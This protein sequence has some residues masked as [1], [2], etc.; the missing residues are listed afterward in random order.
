MCSQILFCT[1]RKNLL[2]KMCSLILTYTIDHRI[3][4]YEQNIILN[5]LL[6]QQKKINLFNWRRKK[7]RISILLKY[8]IVFNV[9]SIFYLTHYH[10]MPHFDALKIYSCGKL[11]KKRRNCLL[12]SNFSFSHN[13][14][15]HIW[16]LVFISNALLN[17][18]CNLFQF[19]PV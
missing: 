4:N 5:L 14:F 2:H 17:V 19:G 6:H 15:Y 3:P 11:C 13:V 16:H 1:V 18:V 8:C 12:T 10:T 7:L 9:Q